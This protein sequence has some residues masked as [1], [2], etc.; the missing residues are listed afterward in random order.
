MELTRCKH[1]PVYCRCAPCRLTC[2]TVE[3]QGEAL[4]SVLS[5]DP[6]KRLIKAAR[7]V[8]HQAWAPQHTGR[9]L[10]RQARASVAVS[11]VSHS[12][13]RTGKCQGRLKGAC[14]FSHDSAKVAVCSSWLLTGTCT[15]P[16]CALQHRRCPDLM[17]LCS[18]F[19]QASLQVVHAELSEARTCRGNNKPSASSLAPA[20]R[21]SAHCSTDAAQ[22]S[23]PSAASSSRH[24]CMQRLC[25]KSLVA[26]ALTAAGAWLI[27]VVE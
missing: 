2:W 10:C 5:A 18:F 7:R 4:L 26:V 21:P 3:C 9:D 13:C 14:P 8:S 11:N 23:C 6:S 27:P 22:T 25:T 15:T 20:R 24:A 19:L 1:C 17:P 16:Q 12:A